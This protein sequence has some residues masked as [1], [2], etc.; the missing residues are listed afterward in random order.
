MPGAEPAASKAP[1]NEKATRTKVKE[2]T[3]ETKGNYGWLDLQRMT[4]PFTTI[5]RSFPPCGRES[6]AAAG[7]ALTATTNNPG[8][9]TNRE[10]KPFEGRGD[11]M[12]RSFKGALDQ[13]EDYLATVGA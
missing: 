13:F 8:S 1:V 9:E 3:K 10:R 2:M 4:L 5:S 11:S 12:K 7:K 6:S